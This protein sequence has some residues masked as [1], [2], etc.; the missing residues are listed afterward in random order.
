MDFSLVDVFGV[1]DFGGNPVAVIHDATSLDTEAMQRITRW[2]NLSESTFLLPPTDAQAD[3]RVRIFTLER[4]LPFAGHP[5][6]GTCH[7]WLRAGG[8]PHDPGRIVQ[9]CEAG[10][11]PVRNDSGGLAFAAPPL[12]RSGSVDDATLDEI[13][14]ILG[15]GRD[16]I[17]DAAWTD[18]GPGWVTVLLGS[19]KE[20]LALEPARSHPGRIDIGVVG[21]YPPGSEAAYEVRAIF[22]AG[23]GS[24]VEDPVTGSLNASVAQWLLE[25]GRVTAPYTAAQG[26]RLDRTGR[27]S[28]SQADGQL[29]IGGN[30]RTLFRGEAAF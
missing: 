14:G 12:I 22:T 10:L 15:I 2:L 17:V 13:A 8:T 19:A 5:T 25:S 29:W 20:V 6:L 1:A 24:L 7:A 11:V 9:Q 23:F 21:L 18:N 4:E 27:V 28:V 30:T 26:T 16:R 3:Y